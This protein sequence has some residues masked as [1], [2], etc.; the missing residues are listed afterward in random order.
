MNKQQTWK[1]LTSKLEQRVNDLFHS[2]LL[3]DS[4][5]KERKQKISEAVELCRIMS[6]PELRDSFGRDLL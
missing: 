6:R 2:S 4:I 5:W 3:N 1:Y